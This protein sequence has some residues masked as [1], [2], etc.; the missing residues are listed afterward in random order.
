[1]RRAP[2]EGGFGERRGLGDPP[3]K[4]GCRLTLT[5]H[6]STS[7]TPPANPDE[8][9]FQQ[10][11]NYHIKMRSG[12]PRRARSP[13]TAPKHEGALTKEERGA[14]KT[15]AAKVSGAEKTAFPAGAL[16]PCEKMPEGPA[17][18]KAAVCLASGLSVRAI[19]W[20]ENGQTEAWPPP[21]SGGSTEK[22]RRPFKRA[23]P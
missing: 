3:E 2:R 18:T 10:Y 7:R 21:W 11:K 1:M 22:G 23:A 6:G 20:V 9:L 15:L 5:A 12:F 8:S 16:L 19:K 17:L 14:L 4:E 13:R